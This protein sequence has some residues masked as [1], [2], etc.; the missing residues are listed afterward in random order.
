MAL[1]EKSP[2]SIKIWTTSVSKVY[3]WT[4]QVRPATS[5][6]WQPWVNTV[7]YFPLMNDSNEASWKAVTTT[8]NN[9][10]YSTLG[11]VKCANVGTKGWIQVTTS[12]FNTA[13]TWTEQTMSFW[14]YQNV[15]P[16]GTSRWH[17]E[18]EKQNIYSFYFLSRSNNIYRYE[19]NGDA[20]S[21]IDVSISGGDI[22]NW[23]YFT[24]VNSSSWKYIYKNWTL[25]WSGNWSSTPRW[26]RQDPSSWESYIL[27]SRDWPLAW[28]STNWGLRELIFENKVRTA[29]EIADYYNQ[30]KWNYWL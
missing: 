6:W 14:L 26:S 23:V 10:N 13:N 24:L 29:Q 28:T 9:V 12:V 15:M 22:W 30:T 19:W 5:P 7:A 11:W 2:T 4:N 27:C 1:I 21:T 3:V 18:F 8:D 20:W 16:N 25:I 17:F